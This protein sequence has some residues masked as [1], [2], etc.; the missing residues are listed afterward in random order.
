MR[1][2]KVA[3]FLLSFFFLLVVSLIPVKAFAAVG[4]R[5]T[6]YS[7]WDYHKFTLQEY[8]FD[9]P[10]VVDLQQFDMYVGDEANEIIQYENE[11]NRIPAVD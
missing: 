10:K 9:T 8:S 5:A 6:P 1:N 4:D 3:I 7:A 2:S 11:F